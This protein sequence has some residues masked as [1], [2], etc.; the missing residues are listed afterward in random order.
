MRFAIQQR[1]KAKDERDRV[2]Q[3][4]AAFA[5]PI[6]WKDPGEHRCCVVVAGDIAFALAVDRFVTIRRRTAQFC[7]VFVMRC[8]FLDSLS[9]RPSR[10]LTH[11]TRRAL[12]T[13][14]GT[15]EQIR[16]KIL[17]P[18]RGD[19]GRILGGHLLGDPF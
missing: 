7:L 1:N 8:L 4:T 16:T 15:W 13:L 10:L 6:E 5:S 18:F 11:A 3:E 9:L 12:C 2:Q 17:K 14:A 19:N